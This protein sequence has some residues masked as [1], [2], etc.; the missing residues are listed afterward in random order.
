MRSISLSIKSEKVKKKCIE[1]I[2]ADLHEATGSR[3][4]PIIVHQNLN[5]F[6]VS[7]LTSFFFLAK[8]SQRFVELHKTTEFLTSYQIEK[9]V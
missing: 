9:L 4:N 8:V 3:L 7:Q 6:T 2:K 5:A 1:K